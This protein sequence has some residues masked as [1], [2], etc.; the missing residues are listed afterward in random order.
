MNFL[1]TRTNILFIKTDISRAKSLEKNEFAFE[2]K[3]S[4]W[5]HLSTILT[6]SLAS[7]NLPSDFEGNSEGISTLLPCDCRSFTLLDTFYKSGKLK[8]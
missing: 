4:P 3:L 8:L 6:R 2:I 5:A 1:E 7:L